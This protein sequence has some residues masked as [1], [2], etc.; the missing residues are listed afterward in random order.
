MNTS[1]MFRLYPPDMRRRNSCQLKKLYVTYLTL[2]NSQIFSS[3]LK[4]T[5]CQAKKQFY[6]DGGSFLA[7]I[8]VQSSKKSLKFHQISGPCQIMPNKSTYFFQ[9]L[10]TFT[11]HSRKCASK[12]DSI[13]ASITFF[14]IFRLFVNKHNNNM[15]DKRLLFQV[16]LYHTTA[17]LLETFLL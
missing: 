7:E 15:P 4:R 10:K 2:L 5:V 16:S 9:L 11:F 8:F 1:T 3:F 6:P 14:D 17:V 13:Q 12:L